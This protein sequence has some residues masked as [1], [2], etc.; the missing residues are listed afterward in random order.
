MARIHAACSWDSCKRWCRRRWFTWR[1]W[2]Y[3][4]CKSSPTPSSSSALSVLS[5]LSFSSNLLGHIILFFIVSPFAPPS[6]APE[7]VEPA[8]A[9]SESQSSHM[10]GDLVISFWYASYLIVLFSLFSLRRFV[11]ASFLCT[12]LLWATCMCSS[13]FWNSPPASL[14]ISRFSVSLS[15]LSLNISTTS[16]QNI[17][18]SVVLQCKRYR[19][20]VQHF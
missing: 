1:L 11:S 12:S 4:I 15:L 20:D 8:V 9:S 16:N 5:V 17:T 13:L 6:Q 18:V 10:A 19:L 2:W 3:T 14:S 7:T